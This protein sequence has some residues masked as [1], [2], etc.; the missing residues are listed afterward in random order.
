MKPA[1]I[2]ELKIDLGHKDQKELIAICLRM[3]KYKKENKELLTYLLRD[4]DNESHYVGKLKEEISGQYQE[5][6]TSSTYVAKKSLRKILRYMDRF[7][8]YSGNKE[9]EIELRIHYCKELKSSK[10][11]IN[12]SVLISNIYN[13]QIERIQKRLLEIHEDLRFDF[14]DDMRVSDL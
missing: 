4:S 8:K 12:Q 7:V 2:H 5:M 9:S 10:I 6:N 14:E 1:S 11:R 13:R 3:A